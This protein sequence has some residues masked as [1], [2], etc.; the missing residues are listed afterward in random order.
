MVLDNALLL[1]YNPAMQLMST[2]EIA[3]ALQ[4]STRT[5]GRLTKEG[6]PVIKLGHH[7]D[8]Y[9]WETVLG[10]L[11]KHKMKSKHYE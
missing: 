8:R 7:T 9:D 1:E 6:M 11:K 5:I 4:V 3:E 10:W 2:K